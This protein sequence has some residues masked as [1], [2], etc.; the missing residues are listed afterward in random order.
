MQNLWCGAKI[1]SGLNPKMK[2]EIVGAIA[3]AALLSEMVIVHGEKEKKM[4]FCKT[5]IHTE[6]C[7]NDKNIFGDNV[8]VAPH[9]LF[10]DDEYKK[11]SWENYLKRKEQ[12][13]P[14]DKFLEIIQ[15]KDCCHC[16]YNEFLDTY[17]CWKFSWSIPT[18]K[19]GFCS[20]GERK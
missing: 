12:G 16:I 2:T 18:E 19:N 17:C 6:V 10:F 11:K 5:C 13:F 4:G 15:C 9:P 1:A 20:W 3:T 7:L 14:C 8:Y